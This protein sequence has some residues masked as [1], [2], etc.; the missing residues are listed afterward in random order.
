MKILIH[1]NL[2]KEIENLSNKDLQKKI[3]RYLKNFENYFS[4]T[5]NYETNKIQ[6]ITIAKTNLYVFKIDQNYRLIFT[7]E[8]DQDKELNVALLEMAKH[9]DY[10]KKV[11]KLL[12]E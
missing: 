5:S 7:A 3:Y 12:N 10:E 11:Y 9:E 2:L 1:N 6:K 4:S 8:Y